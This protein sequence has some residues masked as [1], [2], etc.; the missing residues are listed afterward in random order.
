MYALS[1]PPPTIAI[2]IIIIIIIGRPRRAQSLSIR[3]HLQGHP[4]HRLRQR[5]RQTPHERV[6]VVVSRSSCGSSMSYRLRLRCFRRFCRDAIP[7]LL[8]ACQ[9]ASSH[10]M[11]S[12]RE[13]RAAAGDDMV[14]TISAGTCSI[15]TTATHSASVC[16]RLA[17][18]LCKERSFAVGSLSE[19]LRRTSCSISCAKAC[20]MRLAAQA[21]R[22]RCRP[23][24]SRCKHNHMRIDKL[25]CAVCRSCCASWRGGRGVGRARVQLERA[26]SA[27]WRT[28]VQ[29][30]TLARFDL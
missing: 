10:A 21:G 22:T 15:A 25:L 4:L 20:A 18:W 9:P 26:R 30:E 5:A 7:L 12:A 1:P 27:G 14:T 17:T 6:D 11:V 24:K 2:I 29:G 16:V 28:C 8:L 19:N 13:G 3:T 23:F